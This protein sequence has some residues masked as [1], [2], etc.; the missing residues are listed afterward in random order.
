MGRFEKRDFVTN[1]VDKA[2]ID[3]EITHG[4]D[5]LEVHNEDWS[6]SLN[7]PKNLY[8]IPRMRDK[9]EVEL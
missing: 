6:Y 9:D 4:L 7:F 8:A 3:H 5:V 2:E 1:K